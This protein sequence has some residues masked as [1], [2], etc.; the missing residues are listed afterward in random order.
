MFVAFWPATLTIPVCC[1][2][3]PHCAQ[4]GVFVGAVATTNVTVIAAED[5]GLP[6]PTTLTCPV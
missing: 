2:L 5:T 3:A 1:G 6:T 4:K